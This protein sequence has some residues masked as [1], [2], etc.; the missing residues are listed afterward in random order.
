[1]KCTAKDILFCNNVFARRGGIEL[2]G[3]ARLKVARITRAVRQEAETINEA[4]TA[5]AR[6]MAVKDADGKPKEILTEN[7]S[8]FDM[9]DQ[10]AFNAEQ[11]KLLAAEID[12]PGE[13]LTESE[14]GTGAAFSDVIDA[15]LP[16]LA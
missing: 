12:I 16:F 15:I 13:K 1:M 2:A 14:L 6:S 11:K 7:G 10:A 8:I 3:A 4:M 9:P 5:L